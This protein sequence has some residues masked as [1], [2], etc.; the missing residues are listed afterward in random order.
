MR[1]TED[2]C[3]RDPFVLADNGYY[4]L[5]GTIEVFADNGGHPMVFTILTVRGV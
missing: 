1:K 2:I 5:H 4:Y 3:I